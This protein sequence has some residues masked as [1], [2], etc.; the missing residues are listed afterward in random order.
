[1]AASDL[2]KLTE[3]F[4][5]RLEAFDVFAKPLFEGMHRQYKLYRGTIFCDPN[6]IER[7]FYY[8][9]KLVYS[10][11][12]GFL[13][14]IIISDPDII[15]KPRKEESVPL[16]TLCET[17][18]NYYVKDLKIKDELKKALLDTFIYGYGILKTGWQTKIDYSNKKLDPASPDNPDDF[19]VND[20]FIKVDNPF[21]RQISPYMFMWDPQARSLDS[22][23]WVGEKIIRP[24]EEVMNNRSYRKVAVDNLLGN[25]VGVQ[26][27]I[28][29]YDDGPKLQDI[30]PDKYVMLYEI[31]DKERGKLIT[32]ADGCDTYL[33]IIDYPYG[34]LEG[35][36][37]G[38]LVLHP[39]PDKVEGISVCD[40]VQDQQIMLN[41]IRTLQ[42]EAAKRANRL[43]AIDP[44]ADVD[45]QQIQAIQTAEHGSIVRVPVNAVKAIDHAPLPQELFI[46]GDIAQ[47]DILRTVGSPPSR[48]G[49][50]AG[51]RTSATEINQLQSVEQY[52]LEDAR[53]IVAD[54]LGSMLK[55]M[56][57]IIAN[58]LSD[59]K[60]I[61]IAGEEGF[62]PFKFTKEQ[63][64]GEF[65]FIIEP[66]SMSR[67][68]RDVE[69]QQLIQIYNI[70]AQLPDVN[71]TEI[72]KEV[73]KKMGFRSITKFF[74]GPITTPQM[75]ES[76]VNSQVQNQVNPPNQASMSA[77]PMTPPPMRNQ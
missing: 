3:L 50:P 65:D 4:K 24:R 42:A 13:P 34:N 62:L 45:D 19:E 26:D 5:Q 73:M 30:D 1:M 37:Y 23:R 17:I 10:V 59:Q 36:H 66:G 22:A 54:F 35:T 27:F 9:V 25:H 32:L 55:K 12:Q 57:Q 76:V 21:M 41:R 18:I 58:K 44:E 33:R 20:E 60:V 39:M 51:G 71:H 49:M 6:A 43:Y 40:M 31:H 69:I 7:E 48:I 14:S 63:L 47:Q 68:S 52:R 74:Q 2:D 67:T 61:M 8:D 11:I 15:L 38:M 64:Q 16:T 70:S 46:I 53:T 28:F 29:S 75:G 77:N 56:F 72:L